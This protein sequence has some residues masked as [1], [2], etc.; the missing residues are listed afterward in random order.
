MSLAPSTTYMTSTATHAYTSGSTVVTKT[1]NLEPQITPWKAPESC[2][3]SIFCSMKGSE[4]GP[5][6]ECWDYDI[7]NSSARQYIDEACHPAGYKDIFYQGSAY[8]DLTSLAFPGTACPQG[9]HKACTSTLASGLA[10]QT[11]EMC[12]P[13]GY[14]GCTMDGGARN[15]YRRLKTATAMWV[16]KE[17]TGSTTVRELVTN[18]PITGADDEAITIYRAAFPLASGAATTGMDVLGVTVA[19]DGPARTGMP[20]PDGQ[21]EGRLGGSQQQSQDPLSPG[22]IAG[23]ALG[24]GVGLALLFAV[25]LFIVMRRRKADRKRARAARRSAMQETGLMMTRSDGGEPSPDFGKSMDPYASAPPS[26][27]L[28]S[29]FP[30]SSSTLLPTFASPYDPKS[31][32]WESPASVGQYPSMET[33]RTPSPGIMLGTDGMYYYI[34]PP[35]L[36]SVSEGAVELDSNPPLMSPPA[37]MTPVEMDAGAEPSWVPT[38]TGAYYGLRNSDEPQMRQQRQQCVFDVVKK[39]QDQ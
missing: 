22:A 28:K 15:C 17:E 26:A 4:V 21:E 29:A 11:Q 39:T 9:W 23:I 6:R 37:R 8:E 30:T 24:A 12:C 34:P 25:G 33:L 27:G 18:S 36:P 1:F 32:L 3:A 5:R 10:T 16:V 2:S 20:G 35:D 31:A 7:I 14:D 13:D 19:G 38:P